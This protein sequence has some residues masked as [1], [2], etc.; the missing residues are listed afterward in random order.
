MDQIVLLVRLVTDVGRDSWQIL[1]MEPH[2]L[3]F[4]KTFQIRTRIYANTYPPYVPSKTKG[5]RS[6]LRASLYPLCSALGEAMDL[7]PYI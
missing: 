1:T 4:L 7:L 5:G 6:V 2:V 3:Y